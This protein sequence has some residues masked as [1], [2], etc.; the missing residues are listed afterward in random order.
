MNKISFSKF[1]YFL[2]PLEDNS[3]NALRTLCFNHG[4]DYTSTEMTRLQGLVT[5]NKETWSKL[6]FHDNTPAII[7]LLAG[8][9]KSLDIFL[10]DFK[11]EKGFSGFNLNL[12]CPSPDVI[13]LGLGCAFVKR[14]AKTQKLIDIFR[15]YNYPISIKLRLGMNLKEK[16]KKVY[17]NLIKNTTPDFFIVHARHGGQKYIEPADFSIY[18]ECVK[19][20]KIIV[21]NGDITNKSQVDHLKSIGVKGVMIGRAGVFNPNIFNMLKGKKYSSVESIKKEYIILADKFKSKDRYRNNVL[22]R[23]GKDKDIDAQRLI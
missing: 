19:T 5:K 4:A 15:K 21:A 14:V 2:A 8:N 13:K 6:N 22:K 3:D 1:I 7:Q 10:K 11:P 9:E 16:Q 23:I 20:G 18:E 17:L 12:G